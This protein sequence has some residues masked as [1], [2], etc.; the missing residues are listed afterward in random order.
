MKNIKIIETLSRRSIRYYLYHET[1]C[2]CS[3]GYPVTNELV[4]SA[5]SVLSHESGIV[6]NKWKWCPK[7]KAFWTIFGFCNDFY[8]RAQN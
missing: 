4:F 2:F 3:F 6:V 5:Y 8:I 7:E 1:I